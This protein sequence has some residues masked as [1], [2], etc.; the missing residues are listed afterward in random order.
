MAAE[1]KCRVKVS[2][3]SID[4][5]KTIKQASFFEFVVNKLVVEMMDE[6]KKIKLSDSD[7]TSEL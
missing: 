7:V 6:T 3:K 2:G 5:E 1:K 4:R